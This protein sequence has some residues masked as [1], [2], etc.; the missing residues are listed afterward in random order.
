MNMQLPWQ[1][2]RRPVASSIPIAKTRIGD[3][4]K[5]KRDA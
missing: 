4:R 3:K 2:A 1:A 5:L